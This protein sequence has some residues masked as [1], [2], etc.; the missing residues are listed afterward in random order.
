MSIDSFP[1]VHYSEQ[2]LERENIRHGVDFSKCQMKNILAAYAS[3]D[4]LDIEAVSPYLIDYNTHTGEMWGNLL[5]PVDVTGI[6]IAKLLRTEFPRARMVSLYDEYNSEF[7]D[8]SDASGKPTRDAAQLPFSDGVKRNFRASFEQV[9]R[10]QGVISD[11]DKEGEAY[12]LISESEKVRDVEKLI[13]RLEGAGHIRRD[14]MA[15]YFENAEAENPEHRTIVLRTKNGR[16]LCEALD[17]SSFLNPENLEMTHLVIL[18]NSFKKQQDKV[19]EILR[20]LGIDAS[21]YHNIFFDEDLTPEHVVRV[22]R[23]EIK[24]ERRFVGY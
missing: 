5:T 8:S 6:E 18:P 2:T 11:T 12:L 15:I 4:K 16:W 22:I 17:A 21:R 7:T 13:E 24:K 10:A 20:T 23:D 9:L 14:G 1:R 3:G 19:W